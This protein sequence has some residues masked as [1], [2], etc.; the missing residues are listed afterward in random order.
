M[1]V[2][3]HAHLVSSRA[4]D[5]LRTSCVASL[6]S[7]LLG[8]GTVEGYRERLTSD[9]AG[10][11]VQRAV[12]CAVE[13]S[14]LSAG[15][16]ETLEFC[17]EHPEFLYGV[18]LDPRSATLERDV[19]EAVAGGAVLVKLHPSFQR[20]DP[21]DDACL[22]FWRMMAE[23]RMPVL[24]HTGPEHMLRGGSNR[25]NDPSRLLRA[26]ES[27]VTLI[28]AHC[29]CRMMLHERNGVRGWMDLAA[30]FPNVYG[31]ASAFCGCVRHHWLRRILA[32]ERL[33]G[34]L[35]FGTDYPAFPSVFRRRSHNLFSEW[36]D[37]FRDNGCDD[38]FFTRGAGLLRREVAR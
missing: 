12:I 24:V 15:N 37:F 19:E 17:R 20:L 6:V 13:H 4:A 14:S 18:N 30:R 16:A 34:K 8:I 2:D 21:S 25:L 31:D 29:G 35:V 5:G 10:S 28:C 23:V 1:I 36:L 11:E 3:L 26:A 22:P 9:L 38:S 27:G 32:D 33:R 7:R